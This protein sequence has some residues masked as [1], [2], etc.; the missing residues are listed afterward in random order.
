MEITVCFEI[1]SQNQVGFKVTE[2]FLPRLP[3]C[4]GS[5]AWVF[6]RGYLSYEVITHHPWMPGLAHLKTLRLPV[7]FQTWSP[8]I[9]GFS[10][11]ITS[12]TEILPVYFVE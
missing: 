8:H 2:M 9:T 11:V 5:Q 4:L 1:E 7:N 3:G 12:H 6:L 10:E